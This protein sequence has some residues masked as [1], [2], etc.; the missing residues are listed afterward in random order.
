MK[1]LL[2]LAFFLLFNTNSNAQ[3]TFISELKGLA[4]E[5]FDYMSELRENISTVVDEEDKYTVYRNLGSLNGL[6]NKYLISR[7]DLLIKL[8]ANDYEVN[9]SGYY[10]S[11]LKRLKSTLKKISNRIQKL[12]PHLRFGPHQFESISIRM[13]I[14]PTNPVNGIVRPLN[15]QYILV[16]SPLERL[17]NNE[18][19]DIERLKS[20]AMNIQTDLENSMTLIVE[21]RCLLRSSSCSD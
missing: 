4:S 3:G 18:Q 8:E 2:I 10:K 13:E 16:L 21:I 17:L 20:D 6:L 9:N 5:V 1:A 7:R 14:D 11:E 12:S 19:I 15:S